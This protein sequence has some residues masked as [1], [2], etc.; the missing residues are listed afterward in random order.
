M[1]GSS[2]SAEDRRLLKLDMNGRP[3]CSTR[4]PRCLPRPFDRGS[5]IIGGD[6][7][8]PPQ[9]N[10]CY[11]RLPAVASLRPSRGGGLFRLCG[12]N[13]FPCPRLC[14]R[15]SLRRFRGA[16]SKSGSSLCRTIQTQNVGRGSFCSGHAPILGGV[17]RFRS[18]GFSF[19][20]TVSRLLHWR[21]KT[22]LTTSSLHAG[23]PCRYC[24]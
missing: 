20:E 24:R 4:P 1:N 3:L 5:C 14:S 18:G 6:L 9:T 23:L 13:T 19:C 7:L 2:W 12:A 10:Y 11:S 8:P 17:Q 21:M 15:H 16:Q 22:G